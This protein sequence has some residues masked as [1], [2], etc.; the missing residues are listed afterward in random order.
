MCHSMKTYRSH[1]D[2]IRDILN[3]HLVM[4][5]KNDLLLVDIDRLKSEMK[6]L[7]TSHNRLET[8][9]KSLLGD[10]KKHGIHRGDAS[11]PKM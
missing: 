6:T 7:Q 5:K 3:A 4:Q 2:E 10:L 9:Y 11:R 1:R 8:D